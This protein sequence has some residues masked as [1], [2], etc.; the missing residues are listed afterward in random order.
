MG[1]GSMKWYYGIIMFVLALA[2]L[3]LVTFIARAG[4]AG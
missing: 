4:S 3:L 2:L 1:R